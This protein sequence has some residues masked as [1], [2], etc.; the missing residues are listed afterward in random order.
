L[1]RRGT[2]TIREPPEQ[3]VRVQPKFPQWLL[4]PAKEMFMRRPYG[5]P[6]QVGGIHFPTLKRGA[7]EPCASGAHG[8]ISYAALNNARSTLRHLRHG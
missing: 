7:Y 6:R 4:I 3:V 1:L 2:A 8:D 5:T